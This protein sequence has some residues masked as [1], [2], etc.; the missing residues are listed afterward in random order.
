MAMNRNRNHPRKTIIHPENGEIEYR[1]M[2][3]IF[4]KVGS[5]SCFKENRRSDLAQYG[6]GVVAYFQFL[7]FLILIFFIMSV[8]AAP[9]MTFYFSGN[10]SAVKDFKTLL[11]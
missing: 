1:K 4:T 10:N 6:P 3:V 7:K 9:S 8:L 2:S 11:V 5:Y